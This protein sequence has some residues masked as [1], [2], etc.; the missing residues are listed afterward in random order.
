M[1]LISYNINSRTNFAKPS[2]KS[3]T[4][5]RAAGKIPVSRLFFQEAVKGSGEQWHLPLRDLK[6]QVGGLFRA[7]KLRALLREDVYSIGKSLGYKISEIVLEKV[8]PMVRYSL[9]ISKRNT[10]FH[11]VIDLPRAACDG[12]ADARNFIFVKEQKSM[13]KSYLVIL[14]RHVRSLFTLN[15]TESERVNLHNLRGYIHDKGF[16]CCCVLKVTT[17]LDKLRK[18]KSPETIPINSKLAFMLGFEKQLCKDFAQCLRKCMRLGLRP[19]FFVDGGQREVKMILRSLNLGRHWPEVI[20]LDKEAVEKDNTEFISNS[21]LRLFQLPPKPA[22]GYQTE[23]SLYSMSDN[24][25][26]C[27]LNDC[28]Y[29][30]SNKRVLSMCRLA[31]SRAGIV[32]NYRKQD[33]G[34]PIDTSNRI[35]IENRSL[36]QSRKTNTRQNPFQSA[37]F[38][39]RSRANLKCLFLV[40]QDFARLGRILKKE[41]LVVEMNQIPFRQETNELDLLKRYGQLIQANATSS[42][43]RR[44]SSGGFWIF[45][46]SSRAST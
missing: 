4:P 17:N 38:W 5:P 9:Q 21:L 27:N 8:E 37:T 35:L 43:G 33:S 41:D 28:D 26:A 3:P 34:D 20:K 10:Q 13:N 36:F 32:F 24:V 14:T 11:Y 12:E 16:S 15:W 42:S 1:S 22:E 18:V 46:F 39:R 2:A 40:Q 31:F 30:L 6:A 44:R 25:I 7:D 23:L 19:E 29:F 45:C